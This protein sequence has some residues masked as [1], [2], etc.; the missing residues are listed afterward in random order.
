MEEIYD[1][2][3]LEDQEKMEKADLFC[4][5][6]EMNNDESFLYVADL[7]EYRAKHYSSI[8]SMFIQSKSDSRG[9]LSQKAK[10]FCAKHGILLK[11]FSRQHFDAEFYA[12]LIEHSTSK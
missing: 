6:Y 7:E 10:E 11:E 9:K 2:R 3:D 12:T 4:F 8:P 1:K 5:L